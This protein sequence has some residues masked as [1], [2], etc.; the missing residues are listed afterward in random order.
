MRL[1]LAMVIGWTLLAA[2]GPAE[3]RAQPDEVTVLILDG[4]LVEI[5]DPYTSQVVTVRQT[6]GYH[7]RVTLWR[8]VS[9]GWIRQ[10]LTAD[11]RIGYGGLIDPLGRRQGSGT[12]P[13]GT[14]ELPWAFGLAARQARWRLTFRPIRRGD[15]W[16]QDNASAYYNRYRNRRQGGFRWWLRRGHPDASERLTDYRG[17][18]RIAIVTSFNREQ[19][20]HRGSGI[21]VHV[22]GRGA[23]AGCVSAPLRF[24]RALMRLLDPARRPV[25][26]IGP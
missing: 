23:T 26:A 4:V 16:V 1:L 17:Q 8:R 21:F 15:Y 13:R 5:T 18:Y 3:G 12:T 2:P 25:I 14:F 10:R 24:L 19:V 22:N 6:R 11:G 9:T 20:R 7:A